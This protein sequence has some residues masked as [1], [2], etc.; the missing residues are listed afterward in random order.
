MAEDEGRNGRRGARRERGRV[1]SQ[2]V[3]GRIRGKGEE[4]RK[5]REEGRDG[6]TEER[7]GGK[8]GDGGGGDDDAHAAKRNKDV[9]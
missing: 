1:E 9:P 4:E 7:G 2:G 3:E 8:G 5:E 6:G